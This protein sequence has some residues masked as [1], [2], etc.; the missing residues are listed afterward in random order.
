MNTFNLDDLDN[1]TENDI[2][3]IGVPS[4]YGSIYDEG[5]MKAPEAI[6]RASL[7]YSGVNYDVM[8]TFHD[9]NVV[10]FGDIKSYKDFDS[11]LEEIKYVSNKISKIKAYPI[12]IGG[13]HLITYPII[14]GLGVPKENIGLIWID[15]HL[16]FMDEYPEGKK[17]TIATVLRRIFEI[18]NIKPDNIVI[19]GIHGN[20]H[21]IEEI[22]S[23]KSSIPSIY[24]MSFI[25]NTGLDN[26]IKIIKNQFIDIDYIHITLDLDVIDP[27]FAPGVSVPE[28]GG[29]TSREILKLIRELSPISNSFDIVELNPLKDNSDITAKLASSIIIE[30]ILHR[31]N[32]E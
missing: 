7:Q 21:G 27:A 23:A 24:S 19:L 30:N 1:L 9:Y 22:E 31:K 5:N 14:D 10:D 28:P 18:E 6:R 16:D 12:Y 17:F 15:S 3:I 20:T 11:F 26:I 29:F 4:D 25:E 13:N 8:K 32:G 2:I